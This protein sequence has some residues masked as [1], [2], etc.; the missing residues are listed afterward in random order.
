[1]SQS[2]VLAAAR[3]LSQQRNTRL[4]AGTVQNQARASSLSGLNQI[5]AATTENG[6]ELIDIHLAIARGEL[7][8]TEWKTSKED[9]LCEVAVEPTIGQRQ[10]SVNWL[11]DRLW[12]KAPEVVQVDGHVSHDHTSVDIAQL[13]DTDLAQLIL[14]IDKA[15]GDQEEAVDVPFLERTEDA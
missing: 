14:L 6:K 10:A 3:A 11:A 13:S 15:S 1:M 12:G 7:R 5:I 9:G 8:V 2:G 4:R